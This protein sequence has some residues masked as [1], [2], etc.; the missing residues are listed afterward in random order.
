MDRVVECESHRVEL[1][2]VYSLEHDAAVLEYYP[3]PPPITLRWTALT[4]RETGIVHTPD[5]FVFREDGCGWVECKPQDKLEQLI[6]TAP[7]RFQR[8][9]GGRWRCAPGE[10]VA[11]EY[12]FFYRVW[13]TADLSPTSLRNLRFLQDY[14]DPDYPEVPLKARFQITEA[15]KRQPGLAVADLV[16]RLSDAGY[17]EVYRLIAVGNLYV[18][19]ESSPLAQPSDVRVYPNST[20]ARTYTLVLSQ[21]A[22]PSVRRLSYQLRTNVAMAQFERNLPVQAAGPDATSLSPE[23]KEILAASTEADLAIANHRMEVLHGT[24]SPDSLDVTSRTVDRWREQYRKAELQ[25]GCGYLGLLSRYK[26]AGN[27][28]PRFPMEIYSI[29]DR[30]IESEYGCGRVSTKRLLHGQFVNLCRAQGFTP[31]SYNWLAERINAWLAQPRDQEPNKSDSSAKPRVPPPDVHGDRPWDVT[32]IDH[33]QCSIVLV[34]E[35][36]GATL[37]KPWLSLLL[38]AFSRRVLAFHL[39]FEKP[40]YRSCMMLFRDCVRRHERLPESVMVD[41]GRE[42]KSVFF[43]SL[44]AVYSVIV[45]YRP[46]SG[47][48]FGSVIERYFGTLQSQLISNLAGAAVP[49]ND[50][51]AQAT[52]IRARRE[53]AWTLDRVHGLVEQYL[54][55]IYESQIHSSLGIS[56]A[57]A[58]ADGMEK[59]GH[60]PS[61]HIAYDNDF[62]LQTLPTTRTGTALV[63]RCAGVKINYLYYS[64]PELLT[65][66]FYG[67]KV[68]VR[69]DPFDISRAFVYLRDRWIECR[70]QHAQAFQGH[71]ERE[72]VVATAKLRRR[73]SSAQACKAVT[74]RHLAEFFES[75]RGEEFQRQM[76]RQER[77]DERREGATAG[78]IVPSARNSRDGKGSAFLRDRGCWCYEI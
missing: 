34:C 39:S 31:P 2:F 70:S 19:L 72:L 69:Y 45:K 10:R 47:A 9:G 43:E 14:F 38:D 60:R 77:I 64:C 5:F 66:E 57:R 6:Q 24:P 49:R 67:T 4:G 23:A 25:Y 32:H 63:Q 8:D 28:E 7:E 44:A 40:S 74:S 76:S 16:R 36:T 61:R 27:R 13:S 59:G 12:G 18:D 30:V 37:G 48:R 68:M 35:E 21:E 53:A 42:F 22:Q 15:V 73:L 11:W 33:H 1:S 65:R 56:P 55:E 52:A 54:F 51:D 75:I 58:F 17:D 29:A 20:S 41:G 62:I 46:T 26:Y 3:Q 78:R 50:E 71:T